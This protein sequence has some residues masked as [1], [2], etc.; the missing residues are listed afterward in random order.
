MTSGTLGG[1]STRTQGEQGH[2]TEFRCDRINTIKV[3]MSGDNLLKM[4]NF[5][6][7]Y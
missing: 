2:L 7:L 4:V 5:I 3:I 6:N 1:H